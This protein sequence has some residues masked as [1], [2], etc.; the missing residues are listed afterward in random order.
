ML[1]LWL[2][3]LFCEKLKLFCVLPKSF[4]G[5]SKLSDVKSFLGISGVF[6]RVT[7]GSGGSADFSRVTFGSGGGADFS[8]VTFGSGGGADFSRVTFGSGG[9]ADF[10]RVTFGSG[11]G[12]GFS[13]V[14]VGWGGGADF[15]NV[16]FG[17]LGCSSTVFLGELTFGFTDTFFGT[18]VFFLRSVTAGGISFCGEYSSI[19][20]SLKEHFLIEESVSFLKRIC[21]FSGIT[22]KCS[23]SP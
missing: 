11:G 16:T 20:K 5:I 3:K 10:S 15:S 7:F 13:K 2:L 22:E 6:S 9:G 18:T 14:T 23:L 21:K 1:K 8:R 17:T 4:F 12:T 19:K